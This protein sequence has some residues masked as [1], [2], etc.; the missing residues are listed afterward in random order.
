[1][2]LVALELLERTDIRIAVTEICDHAEGNEIVFHVIEKAAA[3]GA[4]LLER[5][6]RAVYYEP[7]TVLL[8]VD[9]PEFLDA[10]TIV[11]S[12][13]PGIEFEACDEVFAKVPAAAFG[14][15]RVLGVELHSRRIAVLV[16]AT[17]RNT[18]VAGCDA[19]D[20]AV[21]V[22]QH[23]GRRKAGIDLGAK[24]LGLFRKP[25]AEVAEAD[26]VIA[27]VVH[28]LGDHEARYANGA[29]LVA[30]HVDF[31]FRHRRVQRRTHGFPVG[32]ELVERPRL[33]YR[34]GENVRA[35]LRSLFDHADTQVRAFFG[36]QLP[37]AARRRK[38]GRARAN[39]HHIV[40]HGFPGHRAS[41]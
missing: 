23:L 8:R 14:K 37:Q 21:L 10:E 36:G 13:A 3:V 31:V 11:L 27:F 33:E 15:E 40:F 1:M 4:A 35:D 9:F 26:D 32:E 41:P 7:L 20:P 19:L 6:P 12:T 39:D 28:G 30:H 2:R 25:A 17:G 5:P 22:E 16:L 29:A 24:P 34:T 38:A 18:H